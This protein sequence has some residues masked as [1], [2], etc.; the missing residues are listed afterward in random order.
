MQGARGRGRPQR[1]LTAAGRGG[2]ERESGA[3]THLERAHVMEEVAV[4]RREERDA[5]VER[6]RIEE[7]PRAGEAEERRSGDEH[8]A[9]EAVGA[10]AQASPRVPHA[11][12]AARAAS[13]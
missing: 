6:R 12:V 9:D 10:H 2:G 13:G 8:G 1:H 3:E 4:V 5:L 11:Q 7:C